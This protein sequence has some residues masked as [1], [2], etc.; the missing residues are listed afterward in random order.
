MI[1]SLQRY[2]EDYLGRR[3]LDDL[4]QYAVRLANCYDATRSELTREQ[5]L[6]RMRRI[7]TILYKNAARPV[8]RGEFESQLLGRLD[9]QFKK[10]RNSPKHSQEAFRRKRN[11]SNPSRGTSRAS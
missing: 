5:F 2:I 11:D 1:F 9:A 4:D 10:K 3:G 7:R 8:D 6:S